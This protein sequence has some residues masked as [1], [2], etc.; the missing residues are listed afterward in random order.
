MLTF[1]L[2][3]LKG[4]GTGIWGAF[5]LYLLGKNAKIVKENTELN[6]TIKDQAKTIQTKKEIIN[7]IQ[8][9]KP[10]DIAGNT[11]RMHDNKL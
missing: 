6:T 3:N 4:I 9:T 2:T 7:V 11:K 10:T 5:T 8:K 1:L